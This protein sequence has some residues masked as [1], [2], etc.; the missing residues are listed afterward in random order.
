MPMILG[1]DE[2]SQAGH[3]PVI[4]L[5]VVIRREPFSA[6]R[7]VP[8]SD[9]RQTRELFHFGFIGDDEVADPPVEVLDLFSSDEVNADDLSGGKKSVAVVGPD[10]GDDLL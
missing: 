10:L 6:L 3:S 9:N 1:N 2:F 7:L 5:Q 4:L 8:T